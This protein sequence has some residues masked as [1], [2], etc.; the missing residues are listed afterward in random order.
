MARVG[1]AQAPE[2]LRIADIP[3][4]EIIQAIALHD[5][6]LLHHA[7]LFRR[8]HEA[9]AQIDHRPAVARGQ[10][11]RCDGVIAAVGGKR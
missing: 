10:L 3:G 5:E 8:R 4:G 6:M 7:E 2:L 1:V 9:A 11:G